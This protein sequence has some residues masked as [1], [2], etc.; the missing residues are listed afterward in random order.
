MK[1]SCNFYS[2]LRAVRGNWRNAIF[3]NCGCEICAYGKK[4]I[5]TGF[6]MTVDEQGQL[7]LLLA[8]TVQ[9]LTGENVEPTECCSVLSRRAFDAA[10]SKYIEWH[11]ADPTSCTL[12]QLCL[13]A[14]CCPNY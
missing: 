9:Q 2:F 3:I 13:N 11:A 1:Y 14:G 5:C 6:L 8:E 10:F 7:L 4:P 12:R